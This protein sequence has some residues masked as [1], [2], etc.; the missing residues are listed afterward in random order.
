MKQ[1]KWGMT[2][3]RLINLPE[4]PSALGFVCSL[5]PFSALRFRWGLFATI[6][7]SSLCV[8]FWV[9]RAIR[10]YLRIDRCPSRAPPASRRHRPITDAIPPRSR[11]QFRAGVRRGSPG[12]NH[13]RMRRVRRPP[14][15]FALVPIDFSEF[16]TPSPS[17]RRRAPSTPSSI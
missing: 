5:L 16:L 4:S 17:S 2:G 3:F 1:F 7:V 14:H 6:Y 12:K 8:T 13:A 11:R 15:I 10:A 9:I